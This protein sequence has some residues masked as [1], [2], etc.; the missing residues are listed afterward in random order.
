MIGY[1]AAD[2]LTFAAV[3]P[4]LLVAHQVADHWIQ[5][6]HQAQHKGLPG[7]PGRLACARHVVSYTATTAF[8]VAVVWVLFSLP[9]TPLGFALGQVVSATTHY[10]AD[11]RAPIERLV[12]TKLMKLAGKDSFY[13]LG[14]PREVT[15]FTE[16]ITLDEE[17]YE[18]HVYPTVGLDSP[19]GWDNPSLGTGAYALDQSWHWFWLFVTAALTATL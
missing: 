7:W 3:L 6:D 10:I 12:N 4:T 9:I 13:R 5:S 2:G 8:M 1:T 19:R 18:L 15:A 17:D 16:V 14:A 11:R